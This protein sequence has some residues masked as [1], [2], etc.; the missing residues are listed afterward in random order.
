[1]MIVFEWKLQMHD[2]T[3]FPLFKVSKHTKNNK[4]PHPTSR[5]VQ[6][7][8]WGRTEF[9]Q[10]YF[11]FLSCPFT[12]SLAAPFSGAKIIA[13]AASRFKSSISFSHTFGV[14]DHYFV[15]LEQPLTMSITDLVLMQTRGRNVAD[16]FID[17]K[18]ESVS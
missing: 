15:M 10:I 16:C 12:F 17:N 9:N 7:I 4:L 18:G 8:D 1:M 14:T 13:T 2:A 6:V 11:I 5:V 3:S